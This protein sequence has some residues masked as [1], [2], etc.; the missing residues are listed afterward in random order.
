MDPSSPRVLPS[1]GSPYD[2]MGLRQFCSRG[3]HRFP[4][5]LFHTVSESVKCVDR[6]IGVCWSLYIF[7]FVFLVLQNCEVSRWPLLCLFPKHI[8]DSWP[9]AHTKNPPRRGKYFAP[10]EKPTFIHF[11]SL[12]NLGCSALCC[13][14]NFLSASGEFFIFILDKFG[15]ELVQRFCLPNFLFPARLDQECLL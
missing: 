5:F 13:F 9:G 2:G 8:L 1:N 6:Y 11:S 10:K 7:P 14:S 15:V 4:C 12:R 3:F